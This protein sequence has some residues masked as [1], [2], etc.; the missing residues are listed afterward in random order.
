MSRAPLRMLRL[1]LPTLSSPNLSPHPESGGENPAKRRCLSFARPFLYFGHVNG[2]TD[3]PRRA[4]RRFPFALE[5]TS[6]KKKERKNISPLLDRVKFEKKKRGEK[7]TD[8]QGTINI[9][10]K[11]R[12][13][14]NEPFSFFARLSDEMTRKFFIPNTDALQPEKEI[15][16][17]VS[18]KSHRLFRDAISFGR[19]IDDRI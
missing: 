9:G 16:S 8:K 10:Y 18:G 17:T 19:T 1:P 4:S 14:R 15:L 11:S 2:I 6:S 3:R 5:T 7:V 13:H 12:P